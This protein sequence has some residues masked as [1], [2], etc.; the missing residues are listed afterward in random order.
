MKRF[1]TRENILF[2]LGIS[3]VL[4]ELVS[5]EVLGRPFHTEFLFLAAA[6]CGVGITQLGDK[7]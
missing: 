4:F 5:S 1:I 7:K 6:L 2:G 3:V